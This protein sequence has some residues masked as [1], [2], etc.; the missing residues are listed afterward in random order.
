MM[1]T[2]QKISGVSSQPVQIR[3][4]LAAPEAIRE[5]WKPPVAFG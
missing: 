1:A 3:A 5:R 2:P 4:L